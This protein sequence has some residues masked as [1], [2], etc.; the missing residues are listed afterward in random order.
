M[1]REVIDKT[2]WLSR[3]SSEF[4]D[5][6]ECRRRRRPP[7]ESADRF[8]GWKNPSGIFEVLVGDTIS[9][10]IFVFVPTVAKLMSPLDL[11]EGTILIREGTPQDTFYLVESGAL[12]RTKE[13]PDSAETIN[14]DTIGPAAA[15]GFLH[16]AGVEDDDVAY[17]TITA[18]KG[19]CKLYATKG[20]E[21]R[22]L[23]LNN[24][25]FSAQLISTLTKVVR[26]A[27]K[28]VRATV[29][30]GSGSEVD[31]HTS[32]SSVFKVL[33]YD[34]TAWV[35]LQWYQVSQNRA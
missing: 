16:V 2:Q 11:V 3:L 28:I 13:V 12:V 21:F 14:L 24:P 19:G 7:R 27:T 22:A 15:S 35:S 34:T 25:T 5:E 33:C 30:T 32:N 4:K 17:A 20:D 10:L 6:R 18:G 8:S 31:A 26:T 23:C 29:S 1:A 9:S